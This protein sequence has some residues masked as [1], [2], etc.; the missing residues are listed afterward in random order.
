LELDA[1]FREN[2][3][4]LEVQ[5]KQHRYYHTSWYKDVKNSKTLLIVIGKKDPYARIMESSSLKY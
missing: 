3:I 2:Q 5:G 4:A 1:F